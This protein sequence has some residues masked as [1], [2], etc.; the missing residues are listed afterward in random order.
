MQLSVSQPKYSLGERCICAS[1]FPKFFCIE[2]DLP[3]SSMNS[4]TRNEYCAVLPKHI[5][6][7]TRTVSERLISFR[8]SA[9]ASKKGR[10][11]WQF[12]LRKKVGQPIVL[13]W[14]HSF[15]QPPEAG[16]T[17]VIEMVSPSL[18]EIA[19]VMMDRSSNGKLFCRFQLFFEI[20]EQIVTSF[21]KNIQDIFETRLTP[22]V[23]IR[24][25]IHIRL[26]IIT[27]GFDL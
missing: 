11:E 27:K 22:I 8:A 2:S 5:T 17:E 13:N 21:L 20:V 12:F 18:R 26:Y 15:M 4:R 19:S 6:F 25:F 23:R 9:S 24:N 14:K 1:C 16:W 10:K 7:G 3:P